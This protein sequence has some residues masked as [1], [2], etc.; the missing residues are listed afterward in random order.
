MAEAIVLM[1]VGRLTDLLTEEAQFLNVVRDEIQQ[2]VTELMRMKAFLRDADSR[3]SEERVGNL[4]AQVRDLVYDAEDVVETFLLSAMSSERRKVQGG[5]RNKVKRSVCSFDEY[6]YHH[7]F[8]KG[9]KQIQERIQNLFGCFSD[10]DIKS[11]Q[12]EG[13]GSSSSESEPGRLKRFHTFSV[14]EPK[15]FVGFQE[16]VKS[17]VAHLV[18]EGD[19]SYPVIFIGGMGGLGKT[20][21]AEKI[22]NHKTIKKHFPR[23]AWVSISQKWQAKH[24]L[25]R[26]LI[27]LVHEKK[28]EILQMEYDRLVENLL[29]VQ[30]TKN[31]LVVLDDIWSSDAWDLLKAAFPTETSRSKLML[32]S[33]I[34]DLA[35]HVNP[36]CFVHKPKVLDA[37]ESWA[38]LRLKAFPKGDHLN[39]RDIKK[40]EEFGRAMLK[41]CAGLPL[42]IVVLG[43]ILVT[44]PTFIEWEKM[45]KLKQRHFVSCGSRKGWYYPVTEE[46]EKR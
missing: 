26:I 36:R 30:Q 24:V 22:Y 20:T 27:S 43:G 32:T 12:N 38:L 3:I 21:L 34:L 8:I 7:K 16:D 25:K 23:L 6:F 29:Q 15:L 9:I 39:S 10:Y 40:M 31:C 13:H 2:V 18:N 33:R 1:V 19:D 45:K 35:D 42:A 44:K 41:H 4:L 37:E 17:L 5:F 14:V 46:E 28:E 11:T